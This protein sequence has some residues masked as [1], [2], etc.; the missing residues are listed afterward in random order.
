LDEEASQAAEEEQKLALANAPQMQGMMMGMPAS[1][2]N[3]NE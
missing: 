3:N 2:K 1:S